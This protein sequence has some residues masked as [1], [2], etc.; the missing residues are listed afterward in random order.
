MKRIS[1]LA[2]AAFAPFITA[3]G[4]MLFAE[5]RSRTYN[6]GAFRSSEDA[7]IGRK[8]RRRTSKRVRA[9]RHAKCTAWRRS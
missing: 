7:L 5:T 9:K 4:P 1:A 2:A 6:P 3:T 8:R